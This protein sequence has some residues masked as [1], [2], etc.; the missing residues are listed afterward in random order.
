MGM[1]HFQ[2]G[3]RKMTNHP[4]YVGLYG[5]EQGTMESQTLALW[6]IAEELHRIANNMEE[7]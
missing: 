1:S 7:E 5:D 4:N 2:R 3:S 6:A